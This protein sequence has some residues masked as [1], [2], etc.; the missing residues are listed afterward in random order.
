MAFYYWKQGGVTMGMAAGTVSRDPEYK[1]VGANG[2]PLTRF[3]VRV[4]SATDPVS[5]ERKGMFVNVVAWRDRAKFA[6][7]I[8]KDDSVCVIGVQD[9]REYDGKEYKDLVADYIGVMQT[10]AQAAPEAIP[11]PV[12]DVFAGA[13]DAEDY[14]LPF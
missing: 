13:Q 1:E 12:Q 7:N 3:G 11:A 4:G 9:V 10:G 6:K 8:R 5:G 14:D 2:T